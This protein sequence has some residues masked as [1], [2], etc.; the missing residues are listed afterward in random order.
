MK[1]YTEVHYEAEAERGLLPKGVRRTL[2]TIAGL[3][4]IGALYLIA[5]RG[6]ALLLDLSAF[7]QRIFC[8]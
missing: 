7:S 3:I 4:L 8:L 1:T 5:V 6:Q 2:Y